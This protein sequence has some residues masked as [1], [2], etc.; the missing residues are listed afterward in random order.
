VSAR[1]KHYGLALLCASLLLALVDG[2]GNTIERPVHDGKFYVDMARNGVLDNPQL[3]APFAYRPIVPLAAR[4]LSAATGLD[5]LTGFALASRLGALLGLL[6]AFALARAVSGDLRVSLLVMTTTALSY[7]HV[8]FPLFFFPLVDVEAAPLFVL[9]LWA[10]ITRH[11]GICLLVGGVGLFFKEF[12]AIPLLVML[13]VL[14][15]DFAANP[16]RRDLLAI[17][18][19]TLFVA[20]LC[21][22]L[23]RA[24]LPIRASMQFID[25]LNDPATLSLLWTAPLQ[26]GRV[27]NLAF[28]FAAYWLPSLLLLTTERARLVYERLGEWR[29]P[30]AVAFAA[31]GMLALYGG[32][33]INLFSSYTLPI[34]VIVL[35]NLRRQ[36][37]RPWEWAMLFFAL[38]VFNRIAV[39]IPS[40]VAGR[41]AFDRYV[42]FYAGW[43]D[44]TV[45]TGWRSL[46]LLGFVGL[47]QGMRFLL[48]R[49]REAP[50]A[51]ATR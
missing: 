12:L 50:R 17:A 27:A 16:S 19:A 7:F 4:G 8:K 44:R 31:T 30:L 3:A 32:T 45:T 43:S 35:A 46:E 23:P 2:L 36:E 42:D 5:V 20:T 11:F 47:A 15:R 49:S 10:A 22:V 18:G 28:A 38:F 34:Q 33:N 1:A 9:A 39:D 37:V 14:A 6:A 48:A 13:V 21:I 26:P 29:L 24:L 25:P 51:D 40:P 41:E